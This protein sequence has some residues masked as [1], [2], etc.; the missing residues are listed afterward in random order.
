MLE[1]VCFGGVATTQAIFRALAGQER[2]RSYLL[3]VAPRYAVE[4]RRL[5][6][7]Y[8]ENHPYSA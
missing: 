1:L 8:L 4:E 6:R 7:I 2:S 3:V 5:R